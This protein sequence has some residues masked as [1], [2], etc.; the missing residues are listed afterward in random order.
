M[1]AKVGSEQD[2]LKEIA[3]GH[4]LGERIERDNLRVEWCITHEQVIMNTWFQHHQ[5]HLYTTH[6]FQRQQPTSD[7][8]VRSLR[9]ANCCQLIPPNRFLDGFP[10]QSQFAAV[11]LTRYSSKPQQPSDSRSWL[12]ILLSGDVHPNPDP[13]TEDPYRSWGELFMQLFWMG[14]FKVFWSSKRSGVQTN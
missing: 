4:V 5:R 7:G 9:L 13:T 8:T 6:K 1:N 3:G 10:D 12:R 2:P 11:K 14:T